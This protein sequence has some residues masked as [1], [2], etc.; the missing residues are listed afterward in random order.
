MTEGTK[1]YTLAEAARLT[2]LHPG[3]IRKRLT[4]GRSDAM[5]VADVW[6]FTEAQLRDL[7]QV[8]KPKPRRVQ[9]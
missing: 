7:R 3:S 9:P 4:T 2:G 5:K 6:L 1:L 8:A